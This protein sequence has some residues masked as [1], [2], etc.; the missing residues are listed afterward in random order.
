M[1]DGTQ[2]LLNTQ[3][4]PIAHIEL[5]GTIRPRDHARLN[6]WEKRFL[7]SIAT[8]DRVSQWQLEAL[9]AIC[10]TALIK[11]NARRTPRRKRR[12]RR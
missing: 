3:R 5:I 4:R 10:A 11:G 7:D 1:P 9:K 2:L 6:H 8:L 12:T